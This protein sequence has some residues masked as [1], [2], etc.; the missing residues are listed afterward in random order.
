MITW[1]TM[2]VIAVDSFGT[3]HI[4]TTRGTNLVH[5]SAPAAMRLRRS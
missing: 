3:E 5:K 1:I 4:A 2:W